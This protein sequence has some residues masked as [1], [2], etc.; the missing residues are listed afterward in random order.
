[1]FDNN[2]QEGTTPDVEVLI[3][4]E[5]RSG[6][7]PNGLLNDVYKETQQQPGPRLHTAAGTRLL[8]AIPPRLH[9][10]PPPYVLLQKPTVPQ[11]GMKDT[12]RMDVYQIAFPSSTHH[13]EL[14][15]HRAIKK[16]GC[17]RHRQHYLAK[18]SLTTSGTKVHKRKS[19]EDLAY[20]PQNGV[21]G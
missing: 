18:H 9:R 2:L 3:Q 13:T 6:G 19:N 14:V 16:Y 17:G 15:V 5:L 20:E 1:M 10:C 12:G 8:P 4:Q 7:F 21:K 11:E